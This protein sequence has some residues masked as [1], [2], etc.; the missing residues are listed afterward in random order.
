MQH[1]TD[2]QPGMRGRAIAM[3]WIPPL[4]AFVLGVLMWEGAVRLLDI[5]SYLLPAPS[6]I[7]GQLGASW[8]SLLSIGWYTFQEALL[9]FVLG[10]GLGAVA[11]M[12]SV[13]WRW[14]AAGLLPFGVASNAVPIIA[15]APLVGVWFGSTQQTSKI[16]IVAIM[17]FFPTLINTYRGLISPSPAAIELMHSYAATP[18]EVFLK[19]RVPAA[20]PYFFN[21]LKICT[22]L[23]LI[24][25]V[26]SEFFGGPLRALG[27]YIISQSTIGHYVEA[28]AA[29]VVACL[30][31]IAF[32]MV[33]VV[34][35]RLAMPWHVSNR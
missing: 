11:A 31:G 20:L 7:A 32:Y 1:T 17:T 10:C 28:W 22:T 34:A 25:A 16:V 9:G 35:E 13:R 27:V 30:L 33:I 26:V 23:S 4:V 21:A 24:G 14:M 29:I 12:L 19:L 15:L 3:Q 8:R 2:K 6:A 5:A 18:I